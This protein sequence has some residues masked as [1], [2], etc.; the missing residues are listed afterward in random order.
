MVSVRFTRPVTAMQLTPAECP[1]SYGDHSQEWHYV[2]AK[3][4]QKIEW[5]IGADVKAAEAAE[6]GS[7]A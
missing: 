6:N 4:L 2:P 7:I 3:G 1:E 5:S